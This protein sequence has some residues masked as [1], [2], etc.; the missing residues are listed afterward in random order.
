MYLII[1]K[2]TIFITFSLLYFCIHRQKDRILELKIQIKHQENM[3]EFREKLLFLSW[4]D[5]NKANKGARRLAKK[6]S[7]FENNKH[8]NKDV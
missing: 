4:R 6:L 1:F 8:D 3:N 7:R 2:I 5:V